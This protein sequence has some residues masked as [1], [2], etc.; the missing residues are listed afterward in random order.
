ML[1]FAVF[2]GYQ[3]SRITAPKRYF[4]LMIDKTNTAIEKN[5]TSTWQFVED[6][7]S[8]CVTKKSTLLVKML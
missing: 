2:L 8:R 7:A 1:K 6:F 4:G 5:S 3:L